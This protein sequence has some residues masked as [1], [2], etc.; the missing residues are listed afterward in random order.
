M[1]APVAAGGPNLSPARRPPMPMV[2]LLA[3]P[4]RRAAVLLVE[5]VATN[6]MLTAALLRRQGHRVDVAESGTDALRM[7]SAHPYDV[8]FMDLVM[9][10]IDGCEAARRIRALP[11]P[12]GAVA[13]VALTASDSPESHAACI[14]AGMNAV[15]AKPVRPREI[16]EV[17]ARIGGPMPA[18]PSAQGATPDP[19]AALVDPARLADLQ[20][21]LPSGMFETLLEACIEDIRARMPQLHAALAAANAEAALEVAHAL[22]G[23]AGSYGLAVFEQ[24]LRAVMGASAAGD[25]ASAT[26]K[27]QGMEAELDRSAELCRALLR[28]QAA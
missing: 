18:P 9:P 17:L 27:A 5:D 26:A 12:E 20:R 2:D 23:M 25:V 10:G 15:L 14:A 11:G 7:V 6:R 4:C 24:R 21:G 8:V 3:R 28:A 1:I 13:I 22:A 19:G 16:F